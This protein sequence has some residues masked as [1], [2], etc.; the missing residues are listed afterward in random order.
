M[1]TLHPRGI[2]GRVFKAGSQDFFYD[3]H[4]NE[5]LAVEPVLAAVLELEGTVPRSALAPLLQDRFSE[6]EVTAACAALDAGRENEGLFLTRRPVLVPADPA[7]ARPGVCDTN[8]R[9]LVLSLTERCNLRCRYCLHTAQVE[10]ARPHGSRS[11]SRAVAVKSLRYFMERTDP[12][13]QP[14]VSFYGG[15]PLLELDLLEQVVLVGRQLP[16][17]GEIRFVI[18]TNGTNLDEAARDLVVREKIHLQV[19]LDGPEPFHDL[20]RVNGRGTGSHARV[21]KNITAL[22]KLDPGAARRLSFVVTLAPPTDLFAVADFFA[23]FPP[24]VELG[25]DASPHLTVNMAN[26]AGQ[27]WAATPADYA[28]LNSQVQQAAQLYV[29]AVKGKRE[30]ALSPVIRRLFEP[31]MG[32]LQR[33]SR[34]PLGQTFTPGGNCR[35][36]RHKLFVDVDGQMTPC[37]R[38]GPGITLGNMSPGTLHEGITGDRVRGLQDEFF[39]AVRDQCLNCWALR[40]CGVCYAVLG[41]QTGQMSA[42]AGGDGDGR[43]RR[44]G[45][46]P[47]ACDSI[48]AGQERFL[49]LYAELKSED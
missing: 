44:R 49:K 19:S 41:E 26:L 38:T 28:A 40:L 9:H 33:R 7:Q 3:V 45:G 31:G 18:D 24:F 30:A 27:D 15:E 22:L 29:G 48:R 13:H 4:T 10:W 20:H 5:I 23:E 16:R 32:K 6:A 36:G 39:A 42:Q 21:M 43:G 34:A 25:L 14:V 1:N 8:L 2:L 17:G 11:M 35:P 47:G 12:G 46:L 37:E